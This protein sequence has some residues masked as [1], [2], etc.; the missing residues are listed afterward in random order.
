MILSFKQKF[1]WG[2]PTNFKEKILANI[3]I[4]SIRED[5]KNRWT[6]GRLI[7]M[8]YGVR[9][10][11][12]NCFRDTEYCRS[13]Q[14]IEIQHKDFIDAHAVSVLVDNVLLSR[15]EFETLAKNDGFDSVEDFLKWFSSDFSGKIIHWTD[16]RY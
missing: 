7:H 12:Y 5:K 8:A 16:L 10:K 4:H 11:L 2:S 14:E 9:T 3:K 13:T 1:P 15:E 6:V